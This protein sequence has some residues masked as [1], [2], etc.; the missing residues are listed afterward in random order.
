MSFRQK[1][2]LSGEVNFQCAL[3]NYMCHSESWYYLLF[4]IGIFLVNKYQKAKS[5]SSTRM[6][7]KDTITDPRHTRN[8]Y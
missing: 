7:L 5:L 2:T 4:Q 8:K 1:D 6:I 3:Y